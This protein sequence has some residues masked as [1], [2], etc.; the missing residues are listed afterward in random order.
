MGKLEPCGTGAAP[1]PP[2]SSG[3]EGVFLQGENSGTWSRVQ[4]QGG[5]TTRV[6]S[7]TPRC[8][9]SFVVQV[10]GYRGETSP[11]QGTAPVGAAA[12]LAREMP[13]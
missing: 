10:M 8:S 12:A 2:S 5:D 13:P 3:D 11:S 9:G 1:P 6:P 7:A 4:E